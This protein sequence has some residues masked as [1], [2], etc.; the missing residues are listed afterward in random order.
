MIIFFPDNP[1]DSDDFNSIINAVNANSRLVHRV[2]CAFNNYIEPIN[3]NDF[4]YISPHNK[5][6][7][8]INIRISTL[9][10]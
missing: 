1:I 6:K 3:T 7:H 4:F 10:I 8:G 9:S 2:V 5:I